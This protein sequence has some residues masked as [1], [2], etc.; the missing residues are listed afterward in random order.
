MSRQDRGVRDEP[1]RGCAVQPGGRRAA[2]R[3]RDL[4]HLHQRRQPQ[5]AAAAA[6]GISAPG[7][8]GFKTSLDLICGMQF[9]LQSGGD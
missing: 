8:G 9:I 4:P 2:D 3:Q 6:A 1:D 7:K 5:P